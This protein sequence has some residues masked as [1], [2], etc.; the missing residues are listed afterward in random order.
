MH[1]AILAKVYPTDELIKK[2]EGDYMAYTLKDFTDEMVERDH[3]ITIVADKGGEREKKP[4]VV[5][6]DP[7]DITG[8][9]FLTRI[10]STWR[11]IRQENKRSEIDLVLTWDWSGILPGWMFTRGKK[12]LVT[13][14]RGLMPADFHRKAYRISSARY[15]M[16]RVLEKQVSL[17]DLMIANSAN[18]AESVHQDVRTEIVHNGVNF[19]HFKEAE[20]ADLEHEGFLA[21]YFGRFSEEKGLHTLVESLQDTDV[22]LLMFGDG[23]IK[24]ELQEEAEE[25]EV[26]DK[27]QWKG[28]VP[29]EQVASYMKALDTVILPS[30]IEG[31]G[32]VILES[33]AA[34]TPVIASKGTGGRDIIK[35]E[36]NGLTV[37][38]EN[39]VELSE[40]IS[41]LKDHPDL[42]KK[43]SESG[44]ETARDH[45]WKEFTDSY[46]QL[47]KEHL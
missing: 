19:Q 14:L 47:F 27:I 30:K 31:F 46:L 38:P 24:Q 32:S 13:S 7:V 34:E 9:R 10:P 25:L 45:T 26:E 8:A 33:M 42:C 17:C 3:E 29:P 37:E 22:T 18:T 5:N 4:R 11:K 44:V 16:Y 20:E 6:T 40:K 2:S 35:E 41:K 21:G 12:P 39:S 23:D 15:W 36:V 1:V 28:L 43:M